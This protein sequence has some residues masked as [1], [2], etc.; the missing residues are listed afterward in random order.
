M[1]F[2]PNRAVAALCIAIIAIAAFL[3]PGL[4]SVDADWFELDWVLL[5]PVETVATVQAFV[6]PPEQSLPLFSLLASRAPP[7]PSFA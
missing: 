2:R 5:P 3:P 6:A 4:V 1:S 7:S